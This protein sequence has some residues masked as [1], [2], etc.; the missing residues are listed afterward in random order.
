MSKKSYKK[1][2]QDTTVEENSIV[3]TTDK[4]NLLTKHKIHLLL[5]IFSCILYANTLNNQYASDDTLVITSN[6][7]TQKGFSGLKE[8][9]TTDAFVGFFGERGKTLV[10]GGRYRPLS[11]A[12]FAIEVELFGKNQPAISHFINAILYG[13]CIMLIYSLMI[14]LFEKESAHHKWWLSIPFLIAL[15]YA[16][17]PIHTEAVANIKGRDEVMG[18][19][20]SMLSLI[21]AIKYIEVKNIKFLVGFSVS[22]F[23]ALLSK[24]NAITMIGVVVVLYYVFTKAIVKDYMKIFVA[25]I[26]P[27]IIF[28]IIRNIY[29]AAGI[30]KFTKELMNDPFLLSTTTQKFGTLFYTFITYLKL[31]IVPYP[32]THDYYPY[33]IPKVSFDNLIVILSVVINVSLF[34]YAIYSIKKEKS[35]IGFGIM[36]YFITFSIVSQIF[37]TVGTNMNERFVFMPSLGIIISI[38]LIVFNLSKKYSSSLLYSIY[39]IVVVFSFLTIKRNPVWKNDATLFLNDIHTSTNSAK[40][41]MAVGGVLIDSANVNLDSNVRK[42]M[43]AQAI[44]HLKKAIDIYG[45]STIILNNEEIHIGYANAYNLLGNAYYFYNGDLKNAEKAYKMANYYNPG[46]FDSYQNLVTIFYNS[47]KYAESI[48]LLKSLIETSP[49]N[50]NFCY[51]LG[52]AYLLSKQYDSAIIYY[53]KTLSTNSPDYTILANYQIGLCYAR[54]KND[55]N[56][57]IIYLTKA[58]QLDPMNLNINEDLGVAYA[59]SGHPIEAA[60]YLRKCLQIQ[61]NYQNAIKNLATAYQTRSMQDSALYYQKLIVNK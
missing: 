61:P 34:L 5:F 44:V 9:F 33:Q 23:L 16:A 53:Q 46:H 41:N 52:D 58:V 2:L 50:A 40:L 28:L 48:P 51:K 27:S 32:L 10:A 42:E 47:G 25:Y 21:L 24:E 31:L 19:L 38:V 54:Y 57:G 15:L 3:A 37:F 56:N 49:N 20:F 12:S 4:K 36:F 29:T 55:L 59:Y 22:I 1:N 26:I 18:M 43:L 60:T 8:I 39:V 30:K 7:F 6:E 35:H 14:K 45:D 13:L 17:H 11:I